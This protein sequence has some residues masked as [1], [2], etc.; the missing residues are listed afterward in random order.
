MIDEEYTILEK[1]EGMCTVMKNE[2]VT[3]GYYVPDKLGNHVLADRCSAIFGFK[4]ISLIR[5]KSGG[6]VISFYHLK[7]P[8]PICSF[9]KEAN[10]VFRRRVQDFVVYRWIIGSPVIPKDIF[11]DNNHLGAYY[12]SRR[13]CHPNKYREI[14]VDTYEDS[15]RRLLNKR[16]PSNIRQDIEK[17]MSSIST[18]MLYLSAE[19]LGRIIV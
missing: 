18:K 9:L 13:D 11:L 5:M 19:I 12:H 14:F 8:T 10:T 2:E 7:D 1:K 15:V 6:C 4:Q 17:M 3:V 16:N